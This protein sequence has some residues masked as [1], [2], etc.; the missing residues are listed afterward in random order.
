MKLHNDQQSLSAKKAEAQ[1]PFHAE[2]V[3]E[4][5]DIAHR[6]T[7]RANRMLDE[8][9]RLEKLGVD[10][11]PFLE[12]GAGS[13]HRS[14]A[15]INNFPVNGVATD[16]SQNSLKDT[17]FVLSLLGYT[18]SPILICCDSHSLP[19]LPDTFNFVFALQ[20]LH[21]FTNPIPVLQECYRVLA[22]GGHIYFNEEPMDSRLRRILRGNRML[23]EP[24]SFFQKLGYLLKVQKVFWDEGAHER[25]LGMV[26]ARFD[27][28]LWRESLHPFK[29]IE[30][31]VNQYLKLNSDLYKP[32][33]SSFLSGVIGGNVKGLCRK[34]TG[35]EAGSNVLQRLMCPDCFSPLPYTPENS[36]LC[37]HCS[38][39][40]PLENNILRILPKKLEYEL[41]QPL[42]SNSQ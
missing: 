3:L 25:A 30:F 36:L 9:R 11:N 33:L 16:I 12:I 22:R 37:N 6:F 40:Y 5:K 18:R 8:S 27:I 4:N 29:I 31:E 13:V 1:R 38:R 41:Y 14:T 34:D 39:M 23:T 21:H 42:G 15:L 7:D 32:F 20:T 17:P 26:E 19:F 10:F 24:P 35:E 2:A 28:D